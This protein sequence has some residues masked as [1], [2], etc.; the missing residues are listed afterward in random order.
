M[1]SNDIWSLP[2]RIKILEALGS[3]AD[4]RITKINDGEY[5]VVSSTGE[6]E[7]TVRV[8]LKNLKIDSTDSGSVYKGYLGYPSIAVLMLEGVLPFSEKISNAL[9]G[10]KW[11]ELNE[12][13]KAY[14]KTEFVVKKIA[15]RK[16]VNEKEIDDFV[17]KVMEKIKE[18]KIRKLK[19]S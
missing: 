12:K 8:D 10:I 4:K 9:K 5:K 14:W 11:K 19:S 7:Y 13:Y 3:I 2:P 6:R 17:D 15:Q 1:V 16:G 18:L